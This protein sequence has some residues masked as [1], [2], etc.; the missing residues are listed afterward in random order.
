MGYTVVALKDKVM[1]MYPEI[2]QYGISVA[3]NF[4]EQDN[5]YVISFR[6]N[7]RELST[8]L[9]KREADDCMDGIRCVHLG[10]Q[11]EQFIRNFESRK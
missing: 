2:A 5:A 11:V 4:S 7:G 6:R 9:E 3:I 10:V 8:R 1:D